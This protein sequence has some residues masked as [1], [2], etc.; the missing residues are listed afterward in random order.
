MILIIFIMILLLIMNILVLV[1]VIVILIVIVIVTVIV[2]VIIN[3]PRSRLAR[4]S[5]SRRS[6]YDVAELE[7]WRLESLR[8]S[9][10]QNVIGARRDD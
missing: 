8:T 5:S 9:A 3:F 2:I 1:I 10:A 4:P 7:L 6:R